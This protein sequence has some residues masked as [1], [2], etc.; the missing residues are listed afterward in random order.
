MHYSTALIMLDVNTW[1]VTTYGGYILHTSDQGRS[2]NRTSS[3]TEWPDIACNP[4]WGVL[5][6]AGYLNGNVLTVSW[7]SEGGLGTQWHFLGPSKDRAN[8]NMHA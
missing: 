5:V 3:Y 1:M 6:A 4:D 2:W 8:P 7:K